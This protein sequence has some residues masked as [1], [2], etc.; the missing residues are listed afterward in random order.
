[1][2]WSIWLGA[3]GTAGDYSVAANWDGGVPVA[4]DDVS[5]PATSSQAITAWRRFGVEMATCCHPH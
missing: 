1:M 4:T 3:G 5:I 2:A